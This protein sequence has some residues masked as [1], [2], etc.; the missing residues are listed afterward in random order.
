MN[1]SQH[2]AHPCRLVAGRHSLIEVEKRRQIFE[3]R[4]FQLKRHFTPEFRKH[5][6]GKRRI[7]PG[8]GFVVKLPLEKVS[9]VLSGTLG[10]RLPALRSVGLCKRLEIGPA[11]RRYRKIRK[12]RQRLRRKMRRARGRENRRA[13]YFPYYPHC[14]KKTPNVYRQAIRFTSFLSAGLPETPRNGASAKNARALAGRIKPKGLTPRRRGA[15]A[16]G[17]PPLVSVVH[18]PVEERPVIPYVVA[19]L[20]GLEP[21]VFQDFLALGEE[22][23]VNPPTF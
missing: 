16:I 10:E 19:G 20:L 3:N 11:E 17:V 4:R 13:Q 15:A 9:G 2:S 21:L 22:L 8:R 23:L 12:L 7:Y 6:R 1:G 14:C 18:D 5:L